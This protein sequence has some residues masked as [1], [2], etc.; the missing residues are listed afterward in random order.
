[1]HGVWHQYRWAPVL[2]YTV[3]R[4]SIA[5]NRRPE[6]AYVHLYCI[7]TSYVPVHYALLYYVRVDT[8]IA[9][10][11]R[12]ST[13]VPG[14]AH[15]RTGIQSIHTY[16]NPDGQ[17]D[18]QTRLRTT[19][20]GR[21]C[22]VHVYSCTVLPIAEW[23]VRLEHVTVPGSKLTSWEGGSMHTYRYGGCDC[24][25]VEWW[26]SM[27]ERH[28]DARVPYQA[29]GLNHCPSAHC[30]SMPISNIAILMS[31]QA[32]QLTN[33]QSQ[34]TW[35]Q[36]NEKLLDC[37]TLNRSMLTG[38]RC[39]NMWDHTQRGFFLLILLIHVRNYQYH[40]F[41]YPPTTFKTY[42]LF[43]RKS[44]FWTTNTDHVADT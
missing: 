23:W 8:H 3:Y 22:R 15:I 25:G 35:R 19:Y 34:L 7:N 21:Y 9:I 30:L 40:G 14:H 37:E 11:T 44:D 17:T 18:T 33:K 1:M 32:N 43:G 29:H 4:Y 27:C 2:E 12:T 16:H 13:R 36:V 39:R 31:M 5:C 20:S 28:Y 38:Q 10:H 26:W 42:P 24:C 41:V 6:R